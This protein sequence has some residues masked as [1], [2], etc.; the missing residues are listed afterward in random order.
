MPAIHLIENADVLTCVDRAN[1]EWESGDWYVSREAAEQ[2]VGGD[3]YLHKAQDAPSTF[4]GRIIAYR[5]HE[6]GSPL[7]GKV[8]FRFVFAPPYR[9]VISRGGWGM[10]KKYIGIKP[11]KDPSKNDPQV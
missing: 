7:A 4:G 6:A 11:A 10:E 3:L 8:V 5:I 2:L 1:H 9:G